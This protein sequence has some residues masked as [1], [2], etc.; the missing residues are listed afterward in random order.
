MLQKVLEP[1]VGSAVAEDLRDAVKVIRH[2]LLCKFEDKSLA[3]IE[4]ILVGDHQKIIAV[5]FVFI[6]LI[7]VSISEW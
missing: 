7:E 3:E 4:I 6:Q 2:S 1:S 5:K